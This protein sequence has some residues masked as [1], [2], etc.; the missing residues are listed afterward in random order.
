[1]SHSVSWG[2]SLGKSIS[3]GLL[4]ATGALGGVLASQTS[5]SNTDP[6]PSLLK[7]GISST[8]FNQDFGDN[9]FSPELPV[10]IAVAAGAG[11][12]FY[13][14]RK[15]SRGS[16]DSPSRSL[17]AE[18]SADLNQVRPKLRHQLLRLLHDDRPVANRLLAQAKLKYPD[19][20]TDWCAE[21]VLYDLKRDRG[22]Y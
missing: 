2:Q 14:T 12:A 18:D 11:V 22:A 8:S 6:S 5:H 3:I 9:D 21:K 16:A 1:M 19:R 17:A 13:A 20:S 4:V 10:A 7:Q 15:S